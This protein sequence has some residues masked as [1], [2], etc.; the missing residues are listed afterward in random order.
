MATYK[1][2]KDVK[3]TVYLL[4]FER[5][6][7]HAAHYL[8]FAENLENRIKEHAAGHGARLTQVIRDAGIGF[9]L[10]RTWDAQTRTF[11]RALKNRRDARALCPNCRAAYIERKRRQQT[12]YRNRLREEKLHSQGENR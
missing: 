9:E 3:G 8:G 10:V 1:K 4:H 7:K 12:E 5:N 11:E 2:G 6:Y